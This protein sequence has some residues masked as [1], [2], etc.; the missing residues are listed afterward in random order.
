VLIDAKGR[1]ARFIKDGKFRRW[2]RGAK[3]FVKQAKRQ[4]AAANGTPVQ[5]RFAEEAAA[6]VTRKLFKDEKIF[7]IDIVHVP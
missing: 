3:G 4:L 7:G 5:W 2:F 6:D 1:Y